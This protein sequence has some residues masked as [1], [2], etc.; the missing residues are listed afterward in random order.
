MPGS[1][2]TPDPP[3]RNARPGS[4]EAEDHLLQPIL[5]EVAHVAERRHLSGRSD[6]HW[7]LA[8]D[9]GRVGRCGRE[10]FE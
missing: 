4:V 2:R 9:L 5:A 1:D 10:L 3:F 8:V 6:N 7:L